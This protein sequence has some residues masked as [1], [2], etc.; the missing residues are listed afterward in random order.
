[1]KSLALSE[2]MVRLTCICICA[3]LFGCAPAHSQTSNRLDETIIITLSPGADMNKVK[4]TIDQAHGTVRRTLHVNYDNY[5]ILFVMPQTGTADSTVQRILLNADSNFR[6]V[7]RNLKLRTSGSGT[8]APPNDPT[9]SE[10]WNL[11]TIN[12]TKA[13][14]HYSSTLRKMGTP[15]MIDLDSGC[16]AITKNDEL[17]HITQYDALSDATDPTKSTPGDVYG[18]GTA[19][20]DM[21]GAVTDN[22]TDLAGVASF[23]TSNVPHIYEFQVLNGDDS[24]YDS[25]V[26]S[27]LTFISNNLSSLGGPSP[28]N[29]SLESDNSG[30][31]AGPLWSEPAIQTL[32]ETL[33]KQG[34]SCVLCAGDYGT[35]L[36]KYP[37][38]HCRVV[39]GTD[40]TNALGTNSGYASSYIG[41]NKPTAPGYNVPLYWWDTTTKSIGLYNSYGTSFS[42]PTW[43]AGIA[44]LQALKPSLSAPQADQILVETG[45]TLDSKYNSTKIKVLMLDLF[46]AI[47]QVNETK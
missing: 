26:I 1:M 10:Q 12:W 5:S 27:V 32:A 25:S 8:I 18:H 20:C 15:H 19:C 31:G 24:F 40:Q 43:A 9:F 47:Q 29:I 2:N 30:T 41:E 3:L 38:G 14:D 22:D 45:R 33:H 39:Q 28:I 7:R 42:S 36:T 34:C 4:A 23:S 13:R 21:Y 37:I 17:N 44:V 46:A 16:A 35:N 11:A 6:S